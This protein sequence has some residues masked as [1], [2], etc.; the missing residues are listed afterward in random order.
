MEAISIYFTIWNVCIYFHLFCRQFSSGTYRGVLELKK[1]SW[2]QLSP[3][4]SFT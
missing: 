1:S 4:S 2:Q 3:K